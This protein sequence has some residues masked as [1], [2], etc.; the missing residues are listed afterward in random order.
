MIKQD[1]V[2]IHLCGIKVSFDNVSYDK[3]PFNHS[4]IDFIRSLLALL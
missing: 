2:I 1:S 3:T 4:S